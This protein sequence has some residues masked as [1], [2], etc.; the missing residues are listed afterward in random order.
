[1]QE[2]INNRYVRR[3]A[4]LSCS[5]CVEDASRGHANRKDWQGELLRFTECI[6]FAGS[7]ACL[8]SCRRLEAVSIDQKVKVAVQHMT[9]S[10]QRPMKDVGKGRDYIQIGQCFATA[11]RQTRHLCTLIWHHIKAE[12]HPKGISIY[13]SSSCSIYTLIL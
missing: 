13:N 6:I 1:M 4:D 3:M 10:P 2:F 7:K 5:S 8:V 9:R 12:I 11:Q